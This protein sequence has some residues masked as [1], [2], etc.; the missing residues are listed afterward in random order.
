MDWIIKNLF[1][2]L[3]LIILI[4]LSLYGKAWVNRKKAN[5]EKEIEKL[6]SSHS[7]EQFIHKLQFE[8]E[9]KTYDYL[10]MRVAHFERAIRAFYDKPD[11]QLIDR[12]KFL[13]E[14]KKE[15]HEVRETR[16]NNIPFISKEVVVKVQQLIDVS[17]EPFITYAERKEKNIENLQKIREEVTKISGEIEKAIRDRI[18]NLGESKLIE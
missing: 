9:F 15:L 7:K 14:F 5:L 12:D 1:S 11:E 17:I 2:I 6:K 8:K 18:K 16:I 4:L 13:D 10:W 3:N